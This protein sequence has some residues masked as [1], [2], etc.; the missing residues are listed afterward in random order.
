MNRSF[1]FLRRGWSIALIPVLA[2]LAGGLAL[3]RVSAQAGYTLTASPS[4][5]APGGSITAS[6]TAPAGRPATD[7]IGLYV[8]GAPS[9][10]FISWGYTNGATSGSMPFTAP[11]QTGQYEFRYLL[12]DGYTAAAVSN[13]VSVSSSATATPTRTPTLT[14]TPT[15]T[16]TGPTA[17]PT[18]TPTGPTATPTRTPTLTAT[19]TSTP[20]STATPTPTRTPTPTTG[21]QA[22][23]AWSSLQTWPQLAIHT[24]MLPTGK[25]MFWS[26]G[27]ASDPQLW[28]PTTGALTPAAPPGYDAFCS[29]HSFLP[30]GRLLVTG[31]HIADY[32]GLPDA[33]IYSPFT[34]SWTTLP[35]MNAGRWYPTNTTL[36]NG[37]VLVVAGNID[38][39]TNNDLPQ[40][41]QTASG[42]WRTLTNAELYQPNYP[43]MYLAPNGKVFNAG[44][45]R[46]T[47]YLDT[48]G[49]GAWTVVADNGVGDLEWGSSVMYD[50]GKVLIVGGG[51]GAYDATNIA[52]VIDLNAAS[53]AWRPANSMAFARR[54][55][56]ATLLPDGKVL[57]T[58]G[59]G[60]P[61]GDDPSGA[62]Y[63]SEMWDPITEQWSTMAS[64]ATYRGYHSSALLL[65]D[66]RI[67]S[68]GGNEGGASFELY[69]PPY[70]FKGARPTI[71]ADPPASVNYGQTFFVQTADAASIAKVT[72]I[73]LS[74]VT[75]SF[76]ESQRINHL[77]FSQAAGGLDITTPSSANL[78]PPGYYMLYI[79]NGN[80]VPSVAKMIRIAPAAPTPTPTAT[81]TPTATPTPL[82]PT[83]TPTETPTATAT[84]SPTPT[85]ST[86]T[87]TPTA[88]ATPSQTPTATATP[89][90]TPTPT[91]TLTPL[92]PTST[93]TE[94]PT[95]TATPSPTPTPTP[96]PTLTS[97]P[98]PTS[99][100]TP[101]ATATL[102]PS[103]TPSATS[104]PTETP[105]STS[106]PTPSLTPTV[107]PTSTPTPTQTVTSTPTPTATATVTL[108]PSPTAISTLTP[109]HTPTEAPTLTPTATS[110]PTSTP[111]V[112]ET[113]TPTP[114][115]TLTLTP[116]PIATP[117]ESPT[118]TLTPTVI[119]TS[120]ATPT[121]TLTSTPTPTATATVTLSPSPTFTATFTP[122]RTPSQTPSQTPTPTPTATPTPTPTATRLPTGNFTLTASPDTVAPG[123][124]ITVS[125]RVPNRRP[126]TDWIG[127][128]AVGT[129]NTAYIARSYTDGVRSGS[130]T[131]TA[132]G[133]GGWYE[134]RYLL[135]D[136]Y[137][138]TATSNQVLVSVPGFTL[139]ASPSAVSAGGGITA[140]W[141]APGGRPATDR[142]GLYAVGAPNTA[143]ISV[144]YT[145]GATS[146]NLA[147]TAPSQAGQ[148]ELRYLLD[149]GYTSATAS[150]RITVSAP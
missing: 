14:A 88:T 127:L 65:P 11:S 38:E 52:R 142:V 67:L 1:P 5:V 102:S 79:L 132:P 50:D 71:S 57:V 60:G 104:T 28:D 118:P 143:Y 72:W 15:R 80:G 62:V 86:P 29:G 45:S 68:G 111:T 69:S 137:T 136:G 138:S 24:H 12:N 106:T 126:A 77:S 58:G 116:S 121:Q 19:P 83:S 39:A 73:G 124:G 44:P 95:A 9:T 35:D 2:I 145:G 99:T 53:P 84:P 94:T 54:H 139:T 147:F 42:T 18:R 148:Y 6:W 26:R 105:T 48:S 140:S 103:P 87:Q 8:V 134:F 89:S 114:I 40:V 13:P 149:D 36:A 82:P 47:R 7:W 112:T 128:Y 30:D 16:P 123:G 64:F 75:H 74:S 32:V 98:I 41:W 59:T 109:S 46:L 129:P 37:D 22:V 81:R 76:N 70:L 25:V 31:G 17:T 107:I 55:H 97:T 133:N 122:T 23:G 63:A 4:T 92:P 150:N 34:N 131:F 27:G 146:G 144:G 113:S 93:P 78:C 21:P 141:T 33:K 100:A 96:T 120:T 125:W 101:T 110:T 51:A 20:T 61:G 85:T 130:M 56:N 66:G 108:T 117:T 10:D 135:D 115:P 49:T 119:P 43:F 91:P 3:E 90:Q